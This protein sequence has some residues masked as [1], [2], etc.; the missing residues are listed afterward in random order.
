MKPTRIT[1]FAVLPLLA[2]SLPCVAPARKGNIRRF[3]SISS[4]VLLLAGAQSAQAADFFWDPGLSNSNAGS[5]NGTWNAANTNWF[6]GTTDV[7]WA[8]GNRAVFGG[9]DGPFDV[10]VAGNFNTTG[11]IFNKTGYK[12]GAAGGQTLT[13]TGNTT[14]ASGVTATI[15]ANVT[16]TRATNDL[17]TTASGGIT[18]FDAADFI[19]N[20]A[21][22][23]GT[24]G[25]SNAL[26]GGAFSL[27]TSGNNL[28]VTFTAVPEPNAAALLGGLG[29][30][31]LVRRRN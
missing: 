7:V 20:V 27:G 28:V 25:F 11:L 31:A 4:L 19:L 24:G 3:T 21:S 8:T 26:G 17:I 23:N 13:A 16:I 12:L 6:N 22:N 1:R 18:G 14:L 2:S 15:G 30:L 29:M 9:T 5:G 10:T